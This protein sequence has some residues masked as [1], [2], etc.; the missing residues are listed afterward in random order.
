MASASATSR[1]QT[2]QIRKVRTANST[3]ITAPS[4]SAG[5]RR[6]MKLMSNGTSVLV[7]V[8]GPLRR[9][10]LLHPLLVPRDIE[11][12]AGAI[13]QLT[14]PGVEEQPPLEVAWLHEDRVLADIGEWR[15]CGIQTDQVLVL[16]LV[17]IRDRLVDRERCRAAGLH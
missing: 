10:V 14:H 2:R 1:P 16:R 5:I 15:A 17:V 3:V 4:S 6:A 11:L 7:E 13:A 8:V 12:V 9:R